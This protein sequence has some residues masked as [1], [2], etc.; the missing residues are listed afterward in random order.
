[1]L[2]NNKNQLYDMS[3]S[4]EDITDQK[5]IQI[6]DFL[7]SVLLRIFSRKFNKR[8]KFYIQVIF[9]FRHNKIKQ[10]PTRS[11]EG[12]VDRL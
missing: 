7:N 4:F 5:K 9:L 2:N 12:N 10:I 8:N 6:V 11:G 1:M 3:Y